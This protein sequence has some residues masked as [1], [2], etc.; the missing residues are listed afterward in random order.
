MPCRDVAVFFVAPAAVAAAAAFF[1]PLFF[2][3]CPSD[4]L[5]FHVVENSGAWL[6]FAQRL[7]TRWWKVEQVSDHIFHPL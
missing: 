6:W 1:S 7:L 2:R 5:D 4:A 3:C